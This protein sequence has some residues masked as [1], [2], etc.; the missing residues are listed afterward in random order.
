[1][2]PLGAALVLLASCGAD[3]RPNEAIA[4]PVW[5]PFRAEFRS[6]G[7]GS[8][9]RGRFYRRRDGSVRRETFGADGTADFV[10][11]ENYS[12]RRFYSFSAGSWT[13]QPLT[14]AP[15]RAKPLGPGDFPNAT[16]LAAPVAGY[17]VVRADT[18]LGAMIL[19]APSL[20]YFALTEEHPDPPLRVEYDS[21]V[22]GDLADALFAPPPGAVIADMPW[23]HGSR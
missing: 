20:N 14:V 13:S 23:P 16:P 4:R 18:L 21:V 22:E 9:R 10:T 19:R 2:A 3:D 8:D 7:A 15:H 17:R 5:V 1:M 11:I 6:V 12:T